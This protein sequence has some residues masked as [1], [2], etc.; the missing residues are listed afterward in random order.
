MPVRVSLRFLA[1]I[2]VGHHVTVLPLEMRVTETNFIPIKNPI[3]CDD[4]TR[5]VW[6]PHGVGAETMTYES[7]HFA[8]D[9]SFRVSQT[10]APL[11]GRVTSCVVRSEGGER[12]ELE[13]VLG[14]E[15]DP[16]GYR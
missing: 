6:A 7:I 13:T 15:P 16:G 12:V 2:P 5:V 11:R 1:P 9:S 10:V 3:V 8:P 14:V 4:E